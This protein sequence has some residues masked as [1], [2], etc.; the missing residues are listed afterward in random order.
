[1]IHRDII[2]WLSKIG[3]TK[4]L[5]DQ[6]DFVTPVVLVTTLTGT[7]AHQIN[8][9]TL[10]AA[11]RF[12]FKLGSD[13]SLSIKGQLQ[14]N[15]R[16]LKVLIVDECSM[17]LQDLLLQVHVQLC[18]AKGEDYRIAVPF[19]GVS[20]IACGDLFQLPP[21]HHPPIFISKEKGI[22]GLNTNLWKLF[23]IYE[24]TQIVWQVNEH[25]FTSLLARFR[26]GLFS[27]NT[28]RS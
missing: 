8:G 27:V 15:L 10:H 3:H 24:L 26:K 28:L 5:S 18:I 9:L 7:A 13:C 17:L 6:S 25:K 1:M 20:I 16:H 11:L 21:V 2:Q 12:P 19:G 23:K 4:G 14:A 22:H